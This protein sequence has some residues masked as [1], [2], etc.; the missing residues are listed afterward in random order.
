MVE[1]KSD[2]FEL[3]HGNKMVLKIIPDMMEDV[4]WRKKIRAVVLNYIIDKS[5]NL[6]EKNG[7]KRTNKI[8]D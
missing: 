6:E 7:S 4:H 8:I 1:R 3:S 5:I 2:V